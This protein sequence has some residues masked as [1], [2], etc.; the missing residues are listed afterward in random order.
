MN[1]MKFQLN[2][3]R[4]LLIAMEE[5]GREIV[6]KS[7]TGSGKTIMLT[8]FMSEYVKG[9]ARTVFVWLTPG[10]GNLE[11]QSKR[12]MDLYIHNASTKL[13]SDVMTGGFC[14]ND[15]CFINW[16]KLTKKGN[17]ALKDSERTN[18][19]EWIEKA[20]NAGLEFKVI[21]DESHQNFTE[22]SDAI[23]QLFKTDKIIRCSATPLIDKSAK[24]IEISEADVIAEGLIKKLLVINGDFPNEI[25]ADN[26][27][28]YLL[29][30]AFKKQNDLTSVFAVRG[31]NVNPLIVVQLP[32]NSEAL[33]D[34]VI[35]WFKSQ[36]ISI[37]NGTLAVWLS[38]RHDNLEKIEKNDG[39]QIAVIIKQAVATGW[40]CPRA[41]ILVKLREGMDETFKIQTIGRILRMPE[42]HHYKNDLLD[43]CYLYTFDSKFTQG[44]KAAFG[45]NALSAKTIFL[46]N[47][48]KDFSLMKEQRTQVLDTQDDAAAL[49]AITE[50]LKTTYGLDKDCKQ[51]KIRLAAGTES[52]EKFVFS[53]RIERT[54]YSGEAMTISEATPE[55]LNTVKFRQ[56]MNTHTHGREFHNR[57]GR[58][59]L[60]IGLEYASAV[61][62]LGKL[63]ANEGKFMYKQSSERI[64]EKCVRRIFK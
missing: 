33:L 52:A 29:E 17:N 44:A 14:E 8:H 24:L 23:V 2:A 19:L 9:H 46:K 40:D 47:E 64:Q 35:S 7:P 53:E 43:S 54:T 22:K 36:H 56:K 58:I 48:Y 55:Y 27:T 63:F 30:K 62:I 42:A 38:D 61:T 49:Q 32:N 31:L 26:P 15:C 3:I 11:E 12:K 50:Y 5:N 21:I 18:F 45:K 10:K 4:E 13:L 1:L 20:H 59:G 25:E 60:E 51:N 16:E 57:V 28:E 39:K 6:L 37:E 41:H 34:S